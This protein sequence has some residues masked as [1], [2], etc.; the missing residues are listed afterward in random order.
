MVFIYTKVIC[1]VEVWALYTMDLEIY[2][3]LFFHSMNTCCRQG[4]VMD[5][6]TELFYFQVMLRNFYCNF[7]MG[8]LLLRGKAITD[9]P[10]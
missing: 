7:V 2:S 3:I 10:S 9:T 8:L 4:A 6:L 1:M 5:S